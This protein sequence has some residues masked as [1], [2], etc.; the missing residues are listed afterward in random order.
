MQYITESHYSLVS[1]LIQNSIQASNQL[2]NRLVLIKQ[3]QE[4][5]QYFAVI[6]AE[7]TELVNIYKLAQ[8]VCSQDKQ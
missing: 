8:S 5:K 4:T 6:D 3:L 2:L 1:V 7:D